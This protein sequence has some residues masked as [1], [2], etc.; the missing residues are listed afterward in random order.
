MKRDKYFSFV[1]LEAFEPASA[2]RIESFDRGSA[3][4]FIAPHAGLIEFGTSEITKVVAGNEFSYY[5]FEGRK[6]DNNSELHI[7]SSNFDEP[8][9]LALARSSIVVITIH[10]QSGGEIFVNVGG[11]ANAL[12]DT[13][14][15][16][17]NLNGFN[18]SRHTNHLLGTHKGNICN[19]GQ[20]G[21]GLQLEISRGLRELLLVSQSHMERF[22]SSIGASLKEHK[23]ISGSA[24]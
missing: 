6:T 24:S 5:L 21:E 9:A 8:N 15:S 22:S 16:K 10:G 11:L 14:I 20:S 17:L 23:L 4:C 1:Q 18:A 13:V 2:Y 3:V 7:T 19:K 12:G